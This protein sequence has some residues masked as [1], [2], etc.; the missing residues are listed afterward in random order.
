MPIPGLPGGFIY[1][2]NPSI[3]PKGPPMVLCGFPAAFEAVSFRKAFL[4]SS[5]AALHPLQGGDGGGGL[6]HQSRALPGPRAPRTRQPAR[7]RSGFSRD[8]YWVVR[9]FPVF[10][11]FFDMSGSNFKCWAYAGFGEN[12][13]HATCK[14]VLF[15]PS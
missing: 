14:Y 1:Q 6:G 11:G 4:F 8:D 15:F 12:V 9:V 5:S 10:S 7:P 13:W 3:S 2:G